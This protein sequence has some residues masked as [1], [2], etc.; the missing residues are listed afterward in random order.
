MSVL[1]CFC[2]LSQS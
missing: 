2:S 1:F